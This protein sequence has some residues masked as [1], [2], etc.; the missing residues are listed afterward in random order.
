MLKKVVLPAPLG[1]ITLKTVFLR[2][3]TAT[4]LTATRPPKR[5]V[6][7]TASRSGPDARGDPKPA[8]ASVV[9]GPVL[10]ICINDSP[11]RFFPGRA[12]HKASLALV[13]SHRKAPHPA[14]QAGMCLSQG[15]ARP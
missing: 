4:S 5:L 3:V 12:R 7:P 10:F 9:A 14:T 8:C 6:M 15:V 11:A 2:S 1:P 13:G